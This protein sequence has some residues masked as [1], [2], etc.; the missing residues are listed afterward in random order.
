MQQEINSTNQDLE[1]VWFAW[2]DYWRGI[3]NE[4]E[5]NENLEN[6]KTIRNLEK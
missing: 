1:N 6:G 4:V 3:I 2:T 5:M